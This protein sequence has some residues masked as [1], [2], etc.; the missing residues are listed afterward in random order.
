MLAN[1]W[2]SISRSPW[3][4]DLAIQTMKP[5]QDNNFIRLLGIFQISWG[6]ERFLIIAEVLWGAP[7]Q[8]VS[9]S[10]RVPEAS[11]KT[12]LWRMAKL[13]WFLGPFV[14]WKCGKFRAN[15][16]PPL[17]DWHWQSNSSFLRLFPT[18]YLS[19]LS[20]PRNCERHWK[21]EGR[22]INGVL[23]G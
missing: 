14:K 1:L 6:N 19:F 9:R 22:A 21:L 13:S 4:A 8:T 5:K 3:M 23:N 16:K 2:P 20:F 10:Q 12:P 15:P 7:S 11:R 17:E 18:D